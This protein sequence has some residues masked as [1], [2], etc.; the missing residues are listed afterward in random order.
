M[1]YSNLQLGA[2]LGGQFKYDRHRL[3]RREKG[4]GSVVYVVQGL[5]TLHVQNDMWKDISVH[6][7]E[8]YARMALQSL[9][10]HEIVKEDVIG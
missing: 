2:Q 5:W 7:D 1:E 3:V 10:N 6:L 9:K 4:D 8:T